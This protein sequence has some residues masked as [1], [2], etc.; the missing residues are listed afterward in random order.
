MSE[1]DPDRPRDYPD[2]RPLADQPQ[3]RRDF[4]TDVPEDNYVGR[5]EFT[6]FLVLTSGAFVAGQC[7]IAVASL[8]RRTG[9]FPEKAVA[10]LDEVPVGGA[11]EFR[12]PDDHE[13]CVLI[14]LAPD[15]LVAY[16][17]KCPHL[18]CAINLSPDGKTFFCPCHTSAFALDGERINRVPPRGMDPLDVEPF[19]PT[20]PDAVVRVRFRRFRTMT[21]ERIPLA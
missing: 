6:K 20:D 5:R 13:P 18:A 3:W 16:G 10:R 1:P 4:P 11:V 15:R 17:Q 12:Y 21:E 8:F 7:W 14:R 19:D 9:P 2:G